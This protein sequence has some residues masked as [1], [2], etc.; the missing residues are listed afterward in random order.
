MHGGV[1]DAGT[2]DLSGV[3]MLN[4]RN[5]ENYGYERPIDRPSVLFCRVCRAAVSLTCEW[6]H[7]LNGQR[8]VGPVPANTANYRHGVCGALGSMVW[9][10]TNPTPLPESAPPHCGNKDCTGFCADPLCLPPEIASSPAA[11]ATPPKTRLI[12]AYV[13]WFLAGAAINEF[14]W[15]LL[16]AAR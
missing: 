6:T 11:P 16:G 10:A 9:I 7:L 14:A 4:G 12:A 5:Y 2:F 13:L 8:V 3:A 15:R 1:L